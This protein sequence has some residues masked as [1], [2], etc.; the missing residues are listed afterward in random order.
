MILTLKDVASSARSGIDAEDFQPYRV[1]S[2]SILFQHALSVF[3]KPPNVWFQFVMV[4][5]GPKASASL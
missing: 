4:S 3:E 1:R 2:P 5:E